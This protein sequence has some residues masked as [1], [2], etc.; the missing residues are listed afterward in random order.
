MTERE[1]R[2]H[3]KIGNNSRDYVMIAHTEK[4]ALRNHCL[5]IG[6]TVTEYGDTCTKGGDQ[7]SHD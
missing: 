7:S 5:M 2:F 4:E 3:T 6:H 1:H